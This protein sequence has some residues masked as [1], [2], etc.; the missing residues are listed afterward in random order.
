MAGKYPADTHYMAVVNLKT[1]VL[2]TTT[3][4]MCQHI[5]VVHTQN[6]G[7]FSSTAST[8]YME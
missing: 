7:H 5:S 2:C 6:S 3:Y 4:G 1:K 8:T